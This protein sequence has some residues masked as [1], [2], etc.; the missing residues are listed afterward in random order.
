[1]PGIVCLLVQINLLSVLFTLL[2]LCLRLC[3]LLLLLDSVGDIGV[4]VLLIMGDVDGCLLFYLLL[5]ILLAV[6]DSTLFSCNIIQRIYHVWIVQYLSE[7]TLIALIVTVYINIGVD[8]DIIG[9]CII[10]DDCD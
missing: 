4:G 6:I 9:I 10:L 3:L 8:I 5:D 1:M 2:C 7:Y